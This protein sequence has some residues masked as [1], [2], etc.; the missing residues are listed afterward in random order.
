MDKNLLVSLAILKVNFD[1][2]KDYLETFVPMVAEAV[3]QSVD[4]VISTDEIQK[5]V[6]KQFSLEIPDKTIKRI[7]KKVCKRDY[8]KFN[9]NI[10][11]KNEDSLQKLNFR[12]IHNNMIK[13]QEDI[14]EK[15]QSFCK[16]KFEITLDCSSAEEYF[17]NY[18]EENLYKS[19]NNY[20]DIKTNQN[21]YYVAKFINSLME[22]ESYLISYIEDIIKGSMISTILGN[23]DTTNIKEKFNETKVFLD[24][25]LIIFS[26]GYAGEIRRKPCMELINLLYQNN[27][28]IRC[29]RHTYEEVIGILEAHSY[30]FKSGNLSKA[31]G[32]TLEYLIENDMKAS[33]IELMIK[34]LETEM[35][36]INIRIEDKPTFV[37]D[38]SIDENKLEERLQQDINFTSERALRKDIDSISAIMYLRKAMVYTRIEKSKAIFVSSNNR[39]VRSVNNYLV[40][41]EKYKG[42]MPIISDDSLTTILWLKNPSVNNEL[43]RKRLVATCYAS[44]QPSPSLWNKYLKEIDKLELENNLNPDDAMCLR[45]APMMKECLMDISQGEE[46]VICEGTVK[47]ILEKQRK[48]IVEAAT[49]GVIEQNKELK[50]NN[51]KVSTEL[52]MRNKKNENYAKTEAKKFSKKGRMIL[53]IITAMSMIWSITQITT[54]ELYIK[55]VSFS[56]VIIN[57]LLTALSFYNGGNILSI[58][59]KLEDYKYKSIIKKMNQSDSSGKDSQIELEIASEAMEK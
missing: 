24:T 49:K 13:K 57:L 25:S 15:F 58:S 44:V 22:S 29:F 37:N 45:Y 41:E 23:E 5:I 42:I 54:D 10:Y 39:L 30:Q 55:L 28:R 1:D 6:K 52:I 26:L 3:N 56:L 12:E 40:D 11:T 34:N 33:D 14:V 17:Y 46:S 47:Q 4:D 8:I 18:I 59:K 19:L 35:N 16:D 36:K 38:C 9:N 21:N 27:A 43:A 2:N 32:P 7:L 20:Q 51:E 53:I 31:Y 50:A 48:S